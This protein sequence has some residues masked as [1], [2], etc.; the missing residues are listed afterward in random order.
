MRQD[1]FQMATCCW[2]LHRDASA[3]AVSDAVAERIAE[4]SWYLVVVD[5]A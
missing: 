2:H 3:A 5:A 1:C 4:E